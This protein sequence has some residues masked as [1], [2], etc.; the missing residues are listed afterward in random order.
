MRITQEADYALR[1]VLFL[2]NLGYGEKVDAKTISDMEVIPLRFLLK[3]LRKLT[4]SGILTSYRGVN[5]GYA[6]NREPKDVT[7]KDVIEAIEGPIYVNR[8]LEDKEFC[9][10]KKDGQCAIHN[11]LSKVQLSINKELEE[12]NFERLINGDI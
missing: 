4:K 11:A 10:A 9:T 12:I 7:L 5:G 3:L 6:L 1:V 8:C 2:A